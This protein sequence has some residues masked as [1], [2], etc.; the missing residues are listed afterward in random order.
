[1]GA[2][3]YTCYSIQIWI[4]GSKVCS[5]NLE[6]YEF[7]GF[8]CCQNCNNANRKSHQRTSGCRGSFLGDIVHFLLE[9]LVRDL[10]VAVVMGLGFNHHTNLEL[11][12]GS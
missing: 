7:S 4:L 3:L 8:P 5:L 6:R 1:M 9:A 2:L 11:Y 12:K 10:E